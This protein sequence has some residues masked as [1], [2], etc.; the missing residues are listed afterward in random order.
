MLKLERIYK[1]YRT[2]EVETSALDEL[3]LEVKAGEF[4][5]IIGPS[6][7]PH[8]SESFKLST[9]S[10]FVEKLRTA[11]AAGRDERAVGHRQR[12][13]RLTPMSVGCLLYTSRCV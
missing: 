12:G 4:L 11:V 7:W 5:A 13:G 8:L 2:T 9:D 10:F 6:G 3:S 1:V